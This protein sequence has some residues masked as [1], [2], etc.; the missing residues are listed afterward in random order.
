LVAALKKH[1]IINDTNN[2]TATV[3]ALIGKNKEEEAS[4]RR[5]ESHYRTIKSYTNIL[6]KNEILQGANEY[7]AMINEIKI[8]LEYFCDSKGY[9]KEKLDKLM[10]DFLKNLT[11]H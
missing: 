8:V 6:S 10:Y 2:S 3:S 11:E 9:K 7:G 5:E 4:G 1:L